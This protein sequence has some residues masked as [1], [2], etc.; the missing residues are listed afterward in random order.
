MNLSQGHE[1]AFAR[2][3][4]QFYLSWRP[5]KKFDAVTSEGLH[6]YFTLLTYITLEVNT[7]K[8]KVMQIPKNGWTTGYEY[9]MERGEAGTSSENGIPWN[10][11]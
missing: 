11:N 7:R 5:F 9:T 2:V 8:S 6:H 3:T 4:Y 10:C 1:H